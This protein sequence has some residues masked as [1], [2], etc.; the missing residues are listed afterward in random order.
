MTFSEIEVIAKLTS[1][2]LVKLDLT[3]SLAREFK[4]DTIVVKLHANMNT[5]GRIVELNMSIRS[6]VKQTPS[7]QEH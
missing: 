1:R 2:D 6:T 7:M 4:I 3:I 5:N